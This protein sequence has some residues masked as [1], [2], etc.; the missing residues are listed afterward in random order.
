MPD[1]FSRRSNKQE[2]SKNPAQLECIVCGESQDFQQMAKFPC[3]CVYCS[4][5]LQSRVTRAT[6]TESMFPVKCCR[7]NINLTPLY[8]LLSADIIRDYEVKKIEYETVDRTYCA[9]KVCSAFI[10]KGN[11]KGHQ[12]FCSKSPCNTITCIQCKSEWHD[13][14]CPRDQNQELVLAEAQKRG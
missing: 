5:C 11:T 10:V 12:A 4:A 7:N 3:D 14:E 13:G 6:E 8:H 2:D 9:N 1:S